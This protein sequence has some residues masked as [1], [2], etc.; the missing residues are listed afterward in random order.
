M[1]RMKRFAI[2][3]LGMLIFLA[4]ILME[5]SLSGGVLWGEIEARTYSPQIG[6]L[7]LTVKCPLILSPTESGTVSATITNTLN[8]ET[9][10][11][12]AAE[13]SQA[14]GQQR[15]SQTLDLAAHQTQGVQWTVDSSYMIFGR[16][17]LVNVI[18]SRYS[19]LSSRQGACGILVFN[20]FGLNGISSFSLVIFTA[21]LC[22]FLGAALWLRSHWP[23]N[24]LGR[25][26]AQACGIMTGMATAGLL[27][28][29][30]RWWGLI[31]FFDFLTLIILAVVLTEF[32]LFP[33]R[34]RN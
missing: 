20:L 4:G 31:L 28:A 14:G 2:S 11:V 32:V 12:V 8:E 15:L 1:D 26:T 25:S 16:L 27:A 24:Q 33:G 6:D 21:L 7:G 3:T 34:H 9:R 29:L 19:N 10:P 30:P 22:T 17:I 23:L 5:V 18:Q 13:I